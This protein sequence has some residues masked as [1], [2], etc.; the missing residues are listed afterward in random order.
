MRLA[1]MQAQSGVLDVAGNLELVDRAAAQASEA[2]ADLLLTP[3]LFPVGYAPRRLRKE[4]DP[5]ALPGIRAS[6]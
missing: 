3:E 6:L 4:L 5:E 1:L 2:G